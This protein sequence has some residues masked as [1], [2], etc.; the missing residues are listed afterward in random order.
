LLLPLFGHKPHRTAG[1]EP[2]P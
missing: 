1:A 2:P